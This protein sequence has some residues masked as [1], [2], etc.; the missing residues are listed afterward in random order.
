LALKQYGQIQQISYDHTRRIL[1]NNISI[2]F[3]D[4]TTLYFEAA[5]EDDLRRT[6]FS[7]DGKHQHPQILLGLLVSVDGYPL[8]YEIFEGNKFEGKTMLPVIETFKEKYKLNQLI[9]VADAGLLSGD[10]I[11]ELIKS[12]YEFILGAR[13]KNETQSIKDQILGLSLKDTQ[14]TVLTK[15]DDTRLVVRKK[16]GAKVNATALSAIC[17]TS[18]FFN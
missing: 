17:H 5:D 1:N 8:A 18:E 2:V 11:S 15:S 9:V 16:Q 12:G 13:I 3:Y 10:N 6:G 7:K 14:S 4:V